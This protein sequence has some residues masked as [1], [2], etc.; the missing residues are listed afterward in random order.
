MPSIV[1]NM[2]AFAPKPTGAKLCI[3]AGS[4]P[5]CPEPG[6][7]KPLEESKKIGDGEP[8]PGPGK[9]DVREKA[10]PGC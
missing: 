5:I 3:S 1:A 4:P 8:R 10:F 7:G 9:R 2:T 6:C